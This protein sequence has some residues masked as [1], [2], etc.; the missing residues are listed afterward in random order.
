MPEPESLILAEQSAPAQLSFFEENAYQKLESAANGFEFTGERLFA[1]HP[2]KYRLA[3]R[4]IAGGL[5]TCQ[6]ANALQISHNT[7]QAIREREGIPIDRE[8]QDILNTART[9]ARLTAERVRE[10]APTM[11]AR[12]ASIAF[13][14]FAEKMQLLAG[15][16]TSIIGKEETIK[17]ADFNALIDALPLANAHEVPSEMGYSAGGRTQKEVTG[18]EDR[19]VEASPELPAEDRSDLGAVGIE[20]K[21]DNE[22]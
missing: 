13:G 1:R 14:I 2:E 5:G 22:A 7:V 9:V 10:L 11:T 20:P 4:M 6:I 3:V 17:H 8:K 16:A 19:A 15:E 21:A 18:S 12:D